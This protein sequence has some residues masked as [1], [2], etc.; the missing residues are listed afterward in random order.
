ME[1][2]WQAV[3]Q[4]TVPELNA[5]LMQIND[6]AAVLQQLAEL[7]EQIP[8]PY[9]VKIGNCLFNFFTGIHHKDHNQ[10]PVP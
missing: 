10:R 4:T 6:L 8:A 5:L 3:R 2:D 9:A 1:S 7:L